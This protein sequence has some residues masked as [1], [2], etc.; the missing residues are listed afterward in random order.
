MTF[1]LTVEIATTN[2]NIDDLKVYVVNNIKNI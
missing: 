2:M 1:D